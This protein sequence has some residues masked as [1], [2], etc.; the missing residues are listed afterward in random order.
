[1]VPSYI[2]NQHFSH[3]FLNT[4]SSVC[5]NHFTVREEVRV[6]R[7]HVLVLYSGYDKVYVISQ[8]L[9]KCMLTKQM[10]LRQD[11]E[12]GLC[13]VIVIILLFLSILYFSMMKF[14]QKSLCIPPWTR[15]KVMY[16]MQVKFCFCILLKSWCPSYPPRNINW[17]YEYNFIWHIC[18]WAQEVRNQF[19]FNWYT[20]L[21]YLIGQRD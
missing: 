19:R 3:H 5:T 17:V 14:L 18:L 6:M 12:L 4:R 21:L 7:V 13:K 8:V 2:F 9:A 16:W 1:M 11:S 15:K 20:P 10:L